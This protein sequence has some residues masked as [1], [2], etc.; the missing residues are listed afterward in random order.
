MAEALTLSLRCRYDDLCDMQELGSQMLAVLRQWD[1]GS[2]LAVLGEVEHE[3]CRFANETYD[4]SNGGHL[5]SRLINGV[6]FI[7]LRVSTPLFQRSDQNV[8]CVRR[9]V[10]R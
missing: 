6:D 9:R 3:P 10:D 8:T 4:G 1:I 5:P 7:G 2:V